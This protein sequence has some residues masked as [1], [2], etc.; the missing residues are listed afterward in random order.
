MIDLHGRWLL[1]KRNRRKDER[2]NKG[3]EKVLCL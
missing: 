2:E 3:P 1:R